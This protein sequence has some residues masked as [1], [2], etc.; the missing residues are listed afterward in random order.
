VT[1]LPI[2]AIGGISAENARAAIGAGA[3]GVAVISA[4]T[5]AADP[6]R[7]AARILE[8]IGRKRISRGR[9][10]GRQ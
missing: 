5:A 1:G 2:L 9:G 7:E 10:G 3:D 8:S 4:I 6:E